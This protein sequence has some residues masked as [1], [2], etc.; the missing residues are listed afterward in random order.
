MLGTEG[1]S[2]TH[3]SP[4]SQ[5]DQTLEDDLHW[6]I[7]KMGWCKKK[8]KSDFLLKCRNHSLLTYVSWF[9]YLEGLRERAGINRGE[10]LGIGFSKQ[11]R[12][13]CAESEDVRLMGPISKFVSYGFSHFYATKYLETSDSLSTR[14]A[15]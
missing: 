12:K 8:K 5:A 11:R 6:S 9:N 7:I 15:H 14:T 4:S 1:P 3:Q 13:P 10:P 2:V